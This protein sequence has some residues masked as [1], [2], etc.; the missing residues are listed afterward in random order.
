MSAEPIRVL[1]A[2]RAHESAHTEGGYLLLKDL[3]ARAAEDPAVEATVFS[4]SKKRDASGGVKL[5][6]AFARGGWGLWP[7]VQFVRSLRRWAG[8][9]DVV[10]TA[11]VPTATNSRVLRR[12]RRHA[13]RGGTRFVQT[14]TALPQRGNLRSDLF[15]GDAIVCLNDAA[16]S[17]ARQFHDTVS[18]IAPAVRP[19]R[20]QNRPRMPADV[21][22]RVAGQKVVCIPVDL[23]RVGDFDLQGFC[24]SLLASRDDLI[25]IFP[26]RFGEEE[27]AG[28][29]VTALSQPHTDRVHVFATIDWML[30]LLAASDVVAYPVTDM[31]KKFNPPL[32]LL[33]AAQLGTSIVTTS[34]ILLGSLASSDGLRQLKSSRI[35]SWTAAVCEMI[36]S[37]KR[38]DNAN[39]QFDDAYAQYASLY[40]T[41]RDDSD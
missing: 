39:V 15:W 27:L 40:R 31:R 2:S 5:L 3:A 36:D 25:V 16:A 34:S 21:A 32:V 26:C 9:F 7:A 12:I 24:E 11:H 33:E 41:F 38:I 20:L 10:H 17:E 37:K 6:P 22:E 13:N 8:A 35:A 18:T 29:L 23:V 30:D 14:I 4:T 1:F 28:E 19:E